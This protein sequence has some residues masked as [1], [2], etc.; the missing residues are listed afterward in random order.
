[1]WRISLCASWQINCS[2]PVK[3]KGFLTKN[4]IKLK[5][6]K[7]IMDVNVMMAGM[8]LSCVNEAL[9]S[10]RGFLGKVIIRSK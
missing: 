3:K 10:N 1:M 4:K 9:K 5:Y 6:R 8:R 7:V 2:V